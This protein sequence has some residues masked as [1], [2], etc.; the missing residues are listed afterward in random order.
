M[1]NI[2]LQYIKA[3]NTLWRETTSLYEDWAKKKG[4]SYYELLI[5]ISILEMEENCT[6][7]NICRQWFLPKQTVNTILQNFLKKEWI[8]F[9][10][11]ETDKRNKIIAVTEK[12]RPYIEKIG[13]ELQNHEYNVWEKLGEKKGK[14]I[15]EN[16]ILYNK[17][18]REMSL[19]EV[20]N[21]NS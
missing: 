18:F 13:M 21:E 17:F 20:N 7:K 11:S 2:I 10:V 15:I 3:Y 12:G 6:Q 5:I 14:A 1:K 19:E 16:T 9:K 8:L 4:F